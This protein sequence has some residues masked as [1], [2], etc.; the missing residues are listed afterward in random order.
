MKVLFRSIDT[1]T[2]DMKPPEGEIIEL[3]WTDVIFDTETKACEIGLPQA[4]IF[5]ASRPLSP[6]NRAVHH[7]T[8]AEMAGKP[9][10]TEDDLRALCTEGDPAFFVAHNAEFEARWFTPEIRGEMHLICTYKAGLRVFDEAPAHSNQVLRYWLGLDLDPALAGPVHRAAPD[11]YV[12]AHILA[13]MLQTERAS[14]LAG[15]TLAPRYY[16]VCPLTKHKGLKWCDVPHDFLNWM[17]NKPN[18]LDADL[19]QVAREEMERRRGS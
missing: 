13:R 14:H 9:L 11:S 19:K 17:A 4:K 15:W 6:E 8:D 16:P 18:D 3:G 10:C 12:T 7:I 1:E 5:S 2:S